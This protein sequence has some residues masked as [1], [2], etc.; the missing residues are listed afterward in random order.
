MVRVWVRVS[1]SRGSD[2]GDEK[3]K[4]RRKGKG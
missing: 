3:A 2:M 4:G 1:T